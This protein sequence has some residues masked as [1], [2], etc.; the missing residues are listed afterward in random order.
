MPADVAYLNCAYMSPLM[1]TVVE[2]VA[3][4]N[5]RKARPWQISPDDFFTESEQARGLFAQ[6]IDATANDVAIVPAA[7]YG[8]ATAARNLPVGPG[9]RILLLADQFPSNVYS[10]RELAAASGA[11]IVTL[12]RAQDDNWTRVLLEAIDE[13]TAIAALANNHWTDGSIIDLKAVGHRLR[14]VGAA[15][16]L[17]LTQ[18]L[19]AAPFSVKDVQPDFM[20]AASYKWLMGPYSIG[21]MYVAPKWQESEPLEQNWIGRRDSE[22]FADLLNY[23]DGYRP[24]ARRFDMGGRANFAL[25]PGA[26]ASM[27]QLLDWT[28]E[29]IAETLRVRNDA[30][31]DRAAALGLSAPPSDSRA[32][33][34][35]GL[36]FPD[37]P[38]TDLVGRMAAQQVH[39]SVRGTS[40][41]VTPHVYNNDDDVERLMQALT[42]VIQGRD[43]R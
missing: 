6:L 24:G 26:I 38:P 39:I 14:Q 8:I 10:W 40:M 11:E 21:F 3:Q 37:T 5:R 20:V 32:A 36:S 43:Q 42:K 28:P 31:A 15:L 25:M 4:G 1:H 13:N 7:S 35:L 18:S 12:R 17:D 23:K 2:A 34:F 22:N 30:I 19:G 29:A 27:Q 41:R 33:H 9:Q 16:V